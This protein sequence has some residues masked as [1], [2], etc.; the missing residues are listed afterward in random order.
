ML[1]LVLLALVVRLYGIDWDDGHLLHQDER[2][3]LTRADGLGLPSLS[4]LDTLLDADASPW[5]PRWFPYGSLPLYLLKGV[6]LL[7]APLWD[8]D[9]A[10]L[11]IP[12]RA[13]SAA[14]GALTVLALYLLA[15][16]LCDRRVALLA[17][18]LT[19]L[20]A[21]H[22]QA[23]HFYTV[24]GLQTL[25][26]VLLLW[27][28]VRLVLRGERLY[29]LLAGALVAL[30]LATKVSSAPLALPFLLAHLHYP[31]APGQSAWPSRTR[32]LALG[33]AVS[34]VTL[35]LVQPYALLDWD[36]FWAHASAERDMVLRIADY[37]FT[38]QFIDTLPYAYHVRQMALFGLGLPVGAL[39]WAGLLFAVHRAATRREP[40][41][42]LVV[43]W[44]AAHL[45]IVGALPVKFL[46]YLLP[47]TP[48]LLLFAAQ[49]MVAA[50]D[51]SRARRPALASWVRAAIAVT[52]A[53]AALYALA[54]LHVYSV[55]H[56]AVRAA[57]WIDGLDLAPD[58][59]VL[60]EHW[61][62]PL[63]GLERYTVHELP[64][65][66]PDRAEKTELLV[67]L[68]AEGELLVVSS[69]RVYGTI[70]R[71]PERYPVSSRFYR[72]L[73]AGD[74]GYDLARVEASEPTL[75]G[76]VL[77]SDLFGRAGLPAPEAVAEARSGRLVVG[78]GY[79]DQSFRVHDH[80]TALV[81]RNADRIS[82]E[83]LRR[84]LS[85]PSRTS[86][87]GGP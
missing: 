86:A 12:G 55:P 72:M 69:S 40:A 21:L 27:C 22:V 83:E 70:P 7:A 34:G 75:A 61:N 32:R 36:R 29:S 82:P 48:L 31:L 41:Y 71:L 24:E 54:F 67:D 63:P 11:R 20:A 6:Q 33:M 53:A 79:A 85:D 60:R 10:G 2:A 68:L 47:V 56:P 43:A 5:N 37:P 39:V 14:A 58:V 46:R 57:A 42:L 30:A 13:L 3:I 87:P 9:A 64:M 16:D 38:R 17:A 81:F 50:L 77:R 59:V 80:P 18:A 49:V 35:L 66:D 73:F 74:L 84:R 51:W 19:A 62:E 25:F 52:I 78:L 15:R 76:V 23:G 26:T 45:L 44:A 8:L 28:L 1:G 4:H 65:Y